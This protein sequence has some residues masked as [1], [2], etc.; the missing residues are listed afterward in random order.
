MKKAKNLLEAINDLDDEI[1]LDALSESVTYSNK[2]KILRVLGAAALLAAMG[3]TACGV[4]SLSVWYQNYFAQKTQTELSVEQKTYLNENVIEVAPQQPGLTVESALTDGIRI[5]MKLRIT[6]PDYVASYPYEDWH[7]FAYPGNDSPDTEYGDD[8]PD[9]E[10]A[11]Q[12]VVTLDGN[13][14]YNSLQYLLVDDGDGLDY[15]MDYVVLGMLEGFWNP[16]TQEEEPLDLAG[17]TIKIHFRDFYQR[18][19]N[20][21]CTEW[22]DQQIIAGD[23]EFD[24]PVTEDSLRTREMISQPAEGSLRY[25]DME[26]EEKT[27]C[28]K[29]GVPIPYITLRA[30]TVD[31]GYDSPGLGGDFGQEIRAVMKD[32]SE[33]TLMAQWGGVDVIRYF[34]DSPMM[35]DQVDH[36]IFEDGTVIPAS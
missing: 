13:R 15:T 30:L 36:L 4:H 35:I 33:M 14:I 18:V 10:Y 31:I 28:W 9:A 26:A 2:R 8:S 7:A 27:V 22:E 20:K 32:G 34:P 29:E 6:A 19:S 24:I 11:D 12:D 1:I 21:E 16:E 17:K 23:W 5:F 25:L 3:L